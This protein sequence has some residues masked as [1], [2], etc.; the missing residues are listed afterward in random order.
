MAT[1]EQRITELE[2]KLQPAHLT[3][4]RF[5]LALTTLPFAELNRAHAKLLD[6]QAKVLD[7]SLSEADESRLVS[8]LEQHITQLE[9]KKPYNANT[10]E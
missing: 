6:W 3:R 2:G 5:R 10:T 4:E 9:Q 1:L 8:E 7:G